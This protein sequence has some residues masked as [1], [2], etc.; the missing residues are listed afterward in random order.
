FVNVWECSRLQK[1]MRAIQYLCAIAIITITL[2]TGCQPAEDF[3]LPLSEAFQ[4]SIVGAG[5]SGPNGALYEISPGG[6]I[7]LREYKL[8]TS[9]D[10]DVFPA[11]LTLPTRY[12]VPTGKIS[13][14]YACHRLEY[15]VPA[16]NPQIKS[17]VVLPAT[18]MSKEE[19]GKLTQLTNDP[20]DDI[21]AIWSP[22]GES[23]AWASNRTGN[24]QIWV[25]NLSASGA[26]EYSINP[27][28][29]VQGWPEWSPDGSRL[30]Y[31]EYDEESES[32]AIR[33][34]RPDGSG[35]VTIIESEGA[36]DRPVWSPDGNYIAYAAQK[37]RNWD[38]WLASSDGQ[39]HYRLTEDP[40]METNPNWRPDGLGLAYK[41]ARNSDYNLTEEY[42]ISLEN[43]IDKAQVFLWDGPQSIQLNDWSPDGSQIAYTAEVESYASGQAQ[44]SYLAVVS[45]ATLGKFFAKG[46]ESKVLS[47][48]KTLGDRGPVF[49]PDG[50]QIAFWAW[51]LSYRATLWLV[52]ADGTNL[53]QVTTAGFDMYPQ[54]SPSGDKLLFESSR[55]GNMDIWIISVK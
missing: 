45:D 2:L 28:L 34:V 8:R 25:M 53:R 9:G 33:T 51:D 6:F 48:G 46:R 15:P 16:A 21:N 14:C 42:Y 24:W 10:F 17:P 4:S 23:I 18:E 43:G 41:V 38:I 31:W 32:S 13:N 19:R 47:Q 29:A 55:S 7:F 5:M 44:I 35:E 27:N 20:G 37:D 12:I 1:K 26:V 36:L 22:D 54:W 52:N 3:G 30:V 39:E 40:Q 11:R 50:R 49:S